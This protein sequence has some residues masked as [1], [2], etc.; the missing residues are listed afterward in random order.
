VPLRD[1]GRTPSMGTRLTRSPVRDD[2]GEDE[3]VD[4][5]HEQGIDDRPEVAEGARRVADLEVARREQPERVPVAR[6]V[7]GAPS[8]PN[9][10][11]R[12]HGCGHGSPFDVG[13]DPAR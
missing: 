3:T 10:P 9:R 2:Q 1:S 7:A 11:G 4:P 6:P 12:G 5:R 8:S 13:G